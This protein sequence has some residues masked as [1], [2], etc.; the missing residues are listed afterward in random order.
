MEVPVHLKVKVHK[1]SEKSARKRRIAEVSKMIDGL[2]L[3]QLGSVC[4]YIKLIR[5]TNRI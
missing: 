2:T 5:S 1:V 4:R 3:N